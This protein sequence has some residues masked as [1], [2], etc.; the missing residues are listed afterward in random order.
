ML[1]CGVWRTKWKSTEG[2]WDPIRVLCAKQKAIP[3]T[4]IV[5]IKK[6]IFPVSYACNAIAVTASTHLIEINSKKEQL[7]F[8]FPMF[9]PITRKMLM[10][11][12]HIEWNNCT[13]QRRWLYIVH[14]I[15]ALTFHLFQPFQVIDITCGTFLH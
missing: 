10:N 11:C 3:Q 4:K 15:A 9:N 13:R 12:Y 8:E 5:Y 14:T 6:N 1:S 7:F 2:H